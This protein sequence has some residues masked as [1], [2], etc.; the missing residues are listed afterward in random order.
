[1][2]TKLSHEQTNTAKQY[3]K[4]MAD[5][6]ILAVNRASLTQCYEWAWKDERF[7][8]HIQEQA[9]VKEVIEN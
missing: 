2:N 5:R 7:V 6:G 1:M 9:K 4:F 8:K 3:K